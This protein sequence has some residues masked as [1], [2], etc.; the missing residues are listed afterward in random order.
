[1]RAA[2]QGFVELGLLGAPQGDEQYRSHDRERHD[3]GKR[4][5]Y[6]ELAQPDA[7]QG[8]QARDY[9]GAASVLHRSR[10]VCRIEA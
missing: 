6:Q 4:K 3:A 10:S 7:G 1:M 5:R 8:V 9:G 2:A